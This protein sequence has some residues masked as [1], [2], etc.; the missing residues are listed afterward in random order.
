MRSR[1]KLVSVVASAALV[2][3]LLGPVTPAG[4]TSVTLVTGNNSPQGTTTVVV[5]SS[6]TPGALNAFTEVVTQGPGDISN[7]DVIVAP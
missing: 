1:R 2:A 5:P 6:A 4:A 3:G 7:L